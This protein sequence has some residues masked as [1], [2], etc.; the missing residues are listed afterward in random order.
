M[1]VNSIF[2]EV[3]NL[4]R[5][6]E[7]CLFIG[8]GC[9]IASN[10]P[11]ASD[12]GAIL[13][14]LLSDNLQDE[15]RGKSLPEVA[16]TLILTNNGNRDKLNDALCKNFA[17]LKPNEFHKILTKIPQIKTIITTN[18][19]ALIESAYWQD[20]FQVIC[21]NDDIIRYNP[22]GVRLYKIHGD[23]K[24]LDDIVISNTDYR[25]FLERFQKAFYKATTHSSQTY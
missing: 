21:K 6:E 13:S 9:S 3:V 12:F 16:E 25:Q 18:Y 10:A 4:I 20:Y 11:S 17:D 15:V 7:V 5:R 22:N 19:D 2:N 8:S 14:F 1:K 23:C 24:H